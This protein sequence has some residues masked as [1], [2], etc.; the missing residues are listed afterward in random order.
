MFGRLHSGFGR[1]WPASAWRC[2][3][4]L[5]SAITAWQCGGHGSLWVG[6]NSGVTVVWH[7]YIEELW[8]PIWDGR[9]LWH[10]T[11]VPDLANTV[12]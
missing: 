1:C 3:L 4:G 8:Y 11:A 5:F 9:I 10:G 6:F 7:G 2:V 12:V